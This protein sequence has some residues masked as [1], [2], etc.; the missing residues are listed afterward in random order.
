M[1]CEPMDT[2]AVGG[3]RSSSKKSKSAR[4]HAPI[5]SDVSMSTDEHRPSSSQS[6]RVTLSAS[7]AK[8]KLKL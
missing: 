5:D 8:E 1:K 7:N 2:H 4:H 3:E 6:K